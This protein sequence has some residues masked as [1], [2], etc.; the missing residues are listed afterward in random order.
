LAELIGGLPE[1]RFAA[2]RASDDDGRRVLAMVLVEEPPVSPLGMQEDF[3][4]KFDDRAFLGVVGHLGD[5]D[6]FLRG[7]IAALERRA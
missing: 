1:G 7:C 3:P 5:P 4:E 2:F 6:G